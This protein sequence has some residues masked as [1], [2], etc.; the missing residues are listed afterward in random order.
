MP[1][2]DRLEVES[3]GKNAKLE[4]AVSVGGKNIQSETYTILGVLQ[5]QQPAPIARQKDMSA[6]N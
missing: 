1:L 2:M 5:C 3:K 6:T 4:W